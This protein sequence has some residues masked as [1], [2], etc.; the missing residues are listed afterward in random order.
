LAVEIEWERFKEMD[1]N[2]LS[3]AEKMFFECYG[4]EFF[5]DREYGDRYRRFCVP[6]ELEEQWREE[7]RIDLKN[8]IYQSSGC[9]QHNYVTYFC[10][11]VSD[12]EAVALLTEVLDKN[13]SFTRLLYLESLTDYLN[14]GGELEQ[15][16]REAAEKQIEYIKLHLSNVDEAYGELPYMRDYDFSERNL[17]TRLESLQKRL[18]A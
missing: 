5:I 10:R 12:E 4:S 2:N 1:M 18:N 16:I 8:K 6:K 13:D 7:I 11:I 17:L 9:E 3:E 15:Q 14:K